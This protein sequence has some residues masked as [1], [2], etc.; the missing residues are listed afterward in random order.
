M[1]GLLV[2]TVA[3]VG[4]APAM[5]N[6]YLAIPLAAIAA[7]PRAPFAAYTLAATAFLVLDQD[8][9]ALWPGGL[10]EGPRTAA[11]ALLCALLLAGLGLLLRDRR[12]RVAPP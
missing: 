6:Q 12:R 10:P 4:A 3:F 1:E 5:T 2:Y 7:W 9:L 11:Y 8:G